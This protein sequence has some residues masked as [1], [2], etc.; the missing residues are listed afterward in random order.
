MHL[1]F[2]RRPRAFALPAALACAA[3]VAGCGAGPAEPAAD[4][5]TGSAEGRPLTLDNCGV[6][7]SVTAPPERV[8]TMNQHVTEVMLALGLEDR[9]VGTAF[10]DDEIVPEYRDAYEKVPVLADEYPSF[11]DLLAAEPDFVY[12]GFASAFDE[13]QGRGRAALADAGILTY[14]NIEQCVDE[15]TVGTV[16]EE[17]RNVAAIFGV[18]ERGEELI[19]EMNDELARTEAALEGVDPVDVLVVDSIGATVFTSGGS[20]IGS[21]LIAR[22]GGRNVFDDVDDTFADV[23]IEQAA[24][25]APEAILFYDYGSTGI[26]DKR[27]AVLADPLLAGTPAVERERFAVLPLTSALVGIRV[28]DAVAD[29][30]EQLH[31]GVF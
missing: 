2:P 26:E 9:L 22:A 27:A 15:V 31:P 1:P 10:L 17:I 29:I 6:E 13:T 11:E 3:L 30:A 19:S 5:A 12:G 7:V 18:E 20:G 23:S 4:P 8:V 25:R 14:Q 16:E 28:G 24:E 21:D